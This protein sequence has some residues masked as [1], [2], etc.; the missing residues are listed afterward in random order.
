MA[1]CTLGDRAPLLA[2]RV[3]AAH[4]E[5]G[6]HA[7]WGEEGLGWGWG[8]PAGPGRGSLRREGPG[9]WHQSAGDHLLDS[10]LTSRV[11][12]TFW[13][14]NFSAIGTITLNAGLKGTE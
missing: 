7:T 2:A 4:E 5:D 9:P 3:I 6:H 11:R 14:P 13:S 12:L 1:S 8:A 10:L